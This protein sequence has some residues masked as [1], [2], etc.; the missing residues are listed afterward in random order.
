MP[1]AERLLGSLHPEDDTI[2]L[3]RHVKCQSSS[4]VARRHIAEHK[5]LQ[6]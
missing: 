4:D 1:I 6:Q 3:S 2:M 5:I